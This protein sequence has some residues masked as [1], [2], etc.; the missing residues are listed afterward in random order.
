MMILI[1][2]YGRDYKTAA[3][4]KDHWEHNF[5]F[6][7]SDISMGVDNGRYVN[8]QDFDKHAKPEQKEGSYIRYNKLTE[9]TFIGKW[10]EPEELD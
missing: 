8:K 7:V 6:K 1:P 9:L 2:A 10:E 3:Q 4:V 5:D